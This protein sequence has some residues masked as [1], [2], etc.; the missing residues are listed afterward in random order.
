MG[1]APEFV[2]TGYEGANEADV[3]EGDIE[4]GSFG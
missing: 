4:G 3:Y 1:D 2:D